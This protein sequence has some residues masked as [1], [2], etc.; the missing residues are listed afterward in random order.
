LLQHP[1]L[2]LIPVALSIMVAA[3]LNRERFT[4]EQMAGVRYVTLMM[5]Y[6]SSTADIFINGVAESPWLPLALAG[7]ALA[8][9]L[10]GIVLRVRAFLYLGTTFLLIAIITMI[11]YAS[12]NLGWTWLWW[13]AGIVTGA[14][15]IFTFA[16][17]EKKRGEMLQVLEDLRGW[18]R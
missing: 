9:V 8:G 3:Y 1:Q 10:V 7:L 13:V 16:L 5:I 15:I 11:R 6:V 12:V 17:F 14:L 2:W 18:E 4:E